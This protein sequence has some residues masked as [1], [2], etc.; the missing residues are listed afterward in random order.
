MAMTD[1]QT[2]A[3]ETPPKGKKS[4][5]GRLAPIAVFAAGIG[6]FFAFGLNEYV[7]L[8]ALQ[9]NREALAAW[10]AEWGVLA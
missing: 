3:T 7:T 1:A 9:E 10:R 2:P 8:D 4:L 6:A 5:I